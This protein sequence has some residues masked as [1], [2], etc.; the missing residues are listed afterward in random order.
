MNWELPDIQGGFR[1]SRGPIDQIFNICW[2]IEKTREFQKSIHFC[3]IDY[4]KT[5]DCVDNN[6]LWKILKETGILDHLPASWEICIQVKKQQLEP[7]M[8]WQTA[9]K[10]E[11]EY[12]KALYC[13]P[14]Y[15]IYMQYNSS[16]M[17]H[18]M[19]DKLESRLLG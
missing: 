12:V 1:K 9:S 5:V 3:F 16:E 14:A 19:K 18:W 7:D 11:R 17:L 6:Q 10:L 15:L 4:S 8:E 2:I 13:N